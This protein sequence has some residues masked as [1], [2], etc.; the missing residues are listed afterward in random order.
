MKILVKRIALEEEYTIGKMYI[1]GAFF[2]HTLEDKVRPFGEKVWGETAIPSGTY[3]FII[4]WS[5]RFKRKLPLLLDVPMF[6]GIRIHGGNTAVDTHGCL[7]LGVN[8]VKGMITQSKFTLYQF[9]QILEWSKLT[10]FE[11]EIQNP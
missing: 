3:K 1:N 7:L 6:E 4:N 2:C 8:T 5:N 11:I 10:E 9:M